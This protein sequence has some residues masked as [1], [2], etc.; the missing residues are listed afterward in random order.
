MARMKY[1]LNHPGMA[2]LLKDAGVRADLERRAERVLSR[3]RDSARV[4][5]GEYRDGLTTQVRVTD[6]VVVDVVGTAEH[7]MI[8]EAATGN[9]ASA[10]DAAGGV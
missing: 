9:L 4:V 10:L 5:S 1:R 8:V 2:E 7:S 3:A 6:R